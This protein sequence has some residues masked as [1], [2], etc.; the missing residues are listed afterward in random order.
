MVNRMSQSTV[1]SAATLKS[2]D[3]ATKMRYAVAF[4]LFL[5]VVINYMDR[6]NLSVATPLI[7]E[8]FGLDTAQQGL[9]LSAFG[10]T[11][12]AMHAWRMVGRPGT[13]PP[14]VPNLP[15]ALVRS[16]HLYGHGWKLRC[17][18]RF[19]FGRWWF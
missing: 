19:A 1:S 7:S 2:T 15:R 3:K 5:T 11:Y 12:A 14:A 8:E 10:W 18:D 4:M 9:L 17:L 6:S 13:A 16:D